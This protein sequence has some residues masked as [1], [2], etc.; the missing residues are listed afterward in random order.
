MDV[1][2]TEKMGGSQCMLKQHIIKEERCLAAEP[3]YI[4][5]WEN[6]HI[7]RPMPNLFYFFFPALYTSSILLHR[8]YLTKTTQTWKKALKMI[9]KDL[10]A[11][12]SSEVVSYFLVFP[13][14]LYVRKNLSW[15][16]N[17]IYKTDTKSKGTIWLLD[18]YSV[19][20]YWIKYA[21]VD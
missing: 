5:Y 17:L 7:Y 20:S 13:C 2:Q 4:S 18:G 12:L 11:Y 3:V 19:N 15:V 8:F 1:S 21:L 9:L 10:H 16:N 14:L 6:T